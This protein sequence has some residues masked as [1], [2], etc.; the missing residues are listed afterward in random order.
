MNIIELFQS[1]QTQ[2]QSIEYLERIRWADE[3]F[4]PYCGSAN[5]GRHASPDREMARWQCRDCTRAFSVTIGTLFHGTH[6]PLRTWFLVLALMLNANRSISANQIARDLDVRRATIWSMMHRIRS[7]MAADPEQNR[8]L[9]GIVEADKTHNGGKPRKGK[10]RDDNTPTKRS[11]GNEKT[12]VTGVVERGSRLDEKVTHSGDPSANGTAKFIA[13][14]VDLAHSILIP[15]DHNG[16]NRFN[17]TI[18]RDV[19]CMAREYENGLEHTDTIKSLWAFG[20]R[21]WYAS[22]HNYSHKHMP[23]HTAET[24]NKNN[25]C[26]SKTIFQGS[27]WMFKE[28]IA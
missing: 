8:L 10:K 18:L 6:M 4:C 13:K 20:K 25:C 16:Y 19:V 28:V 27:L 24:F 15:D 2:E 17:E 14:F 9:R 21:A 3:P 7:A 1:F 11:R 12:T 26:N 23:R 5:A 22:R